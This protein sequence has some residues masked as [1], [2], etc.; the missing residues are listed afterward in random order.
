M[1]DRA[2]QAVSSRALIGSAIDARS[3]TD[4]L[5]AVPTNRRG[6]RPEQ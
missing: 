3:D 6:S 1:G 2:P 5:F 4:M